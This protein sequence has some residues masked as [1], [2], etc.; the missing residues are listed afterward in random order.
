MLI[1]PRTFGTSVYTPGIPKIMERFHVS[2]TV[3]I[4]GLS[5]YSEGIGISYGSFYVIQQ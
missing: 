1:K 2:Q 4:L 5:L 3:A